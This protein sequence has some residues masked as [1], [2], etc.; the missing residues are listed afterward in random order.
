M[1]R[2]FKRMVTGAVLAG[3][4]AMCLA[5]MAQNHAS[6]T[7]KLYQIAGTVTNAVTEEPVDRATVSLVDE[8]NR[9]TLQ[10]VETA[11]G[12]RF[13]LAPVIAGKYGLRVSR[14]NYLT[15]F[16]NEH[17]E[18]SSA[19]V[20]GEGQDTEHIPFKLK[21]GATVRGIVTDDA[22]EPVQQAEVIL[23]HKT[24]N[25]GLGER[26]TK[27]ISGV[28]DDTG[29][30]E[31]WDLQPGTYELAV[32]ATPWFA[33]HPSLNGNGA[34]AEETSAAAALD[35]AYPVTFY[36]STTEEAAAT[37]IVLAAG[38][39]PEMN[40]ALHAVPAVHLVVRTGEREGAGG[41]RYM[42]TPMLR[43]TVLGEEEYVAPG[44][45]KPGPAGSG[46][47]ELAGVAPGHYSVMEGNPP[48]V[49]EMDARGSGIQEV[50]TAAGVP[51]ASMDIALR[52]ADGSALPQPI[53]LTLISET[54]WQSRNPVR[55]TNESE[56]R[57]EAVTPGTWTLVAKSGETA[58]AVEAIQDSR[59]LRA[60]DRIEVKSHALSLV[61]MLAAGN[62]RVQGF[63][64]K[65]GKPMAGAMI[66]LVPENPAGHWAMFRRDQ[67]DSD[68]SFSLR[69]VA[70]G[71]Y[72]VVAIEDGWE[73]NWAT[74][75][76]IGRYLKGGA[77]VTVTSLSGKVVSLPDAVAVQSR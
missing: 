37:P 57:F 14:R 31:F 26:R 32:K 77:A 59:G 29:G 9:E 10:T 72:T 40:I 76:V 75:E 24:Y 3:G 68:G 64:H 61:A 15:Q 7:A 1:K 33:L 42:E 58:L 47:V 49:T 18:F 2:L 11:D 51:T 16:F 23:M 8:E 55:G 17:D 6:A 63:A 60:D 73:L 13:A 21:P 39:R 56:M 28:T 20:T 62:T 43:Q 66:V 4:V 52:M 44:A 54:E 50:D 34:S 74:P 45:V 38:D 67:S 53:E 69:G 30:F 12:G 65:D 5:A 27:S 71:R 22:G 25:S 19:I 46:W 70:P 35:V 48:R 41:A 36:D